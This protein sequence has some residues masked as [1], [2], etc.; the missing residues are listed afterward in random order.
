MPRILITNDD[1]VDS[2]LLPPL[3]RAIE[4]LGEVTVVVPHVER[5]WV[6]KSISRFEVLRVEQSQRHGVA[7]HTVT[8]TPADCA[9]LAIHTLFDTRPDLV[10][11]GINLGLNFGLAFVLSSGTVGAA[12]EASIAGVPALAFSIALP[13]DAYGLSGHERVRALGDLPQR[14]AAVAADIT[15][16]CLQHGLPPEVDCISVNLPAEVTADSPRAIAPVTRTRYD[17]LFVPTG[18]GGFR[19]QFGGLSID[20]QP[21]GDVAVVS[22]GGVAI[23]PLRFDVS[24]RLPPVLEAA[25]TERAA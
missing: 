4:R 2:P 5:S 10:V 6:G 22:R 25:L 21:D 11:S 24:A 13:H 18:D 9:S 14:A 16:A 15:A 19:H 1:G 3:V 17:R 8:G 12:I 23:T 20:A 7:L